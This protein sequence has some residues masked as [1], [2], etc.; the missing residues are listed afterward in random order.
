MKKIVFVMG[1][2]MIVGASWAYPSEKVS[3]RALSSFKAEFANAQDVTWETGE[4]Y[5]MAA[6]TLN[7]QRIFAYYSPQGDLMSVGRHISSIQLPI[8][9]FSNLKNN[10]T[11]YWISDVLEVNNNEGLHYYVTLE[12]ADAKLILHSNNGGGWTTYSKSKKI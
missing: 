7:E 3:P 11:K 4:N 2:L 9:L 12:T 5:F 8:N 10:Y 1:F 6:F